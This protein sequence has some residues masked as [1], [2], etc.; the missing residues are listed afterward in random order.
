M[1][2]QYNA[3]QPTDF[4][5]FHAKG[6]EGWSE[7]NSA[8]C[9]VQKGIGSARI[10]LP[11][12]EINRL[13]I[14]FGN[15]PGTVEIANITLKGA[16]KQVL[17]MQPD[18]YRL[19]GIQ[20]FTSTETGALRMHCSKGTDPYAEYIPTLSCPAGKHRVF[21]WQE[22]II[23]ILLP[24]IVSYGAVYWWRNRHNPKPAPR[25]DTLHNVEFLRILFTLGVLVAHFFPRYGI[26]QSGGQGVE[27]FFL[28]SGYLLAVT[29][30]PGRSILLFAEQ[31]W[32]RF[33]PLVVVGG[34][35]ANGGLDSF[36]GV[37]MLQNTGLS[38]GDIPNAP[39]W[40]IAVLF[41]CSI[42]Y[43]ALLKTLPHQKCLLIAGVISFISYILIVQAGGN[44]LNLVAGYIPR[45]VF[46]GL[47]GMGLGIILAHY[48]RR[49]NEVYTERA[50]ALLYTLAELAVL[51]YIIIGC[52]NQDVFS[53]F[54]I[55]KPISHVALLSLFIVKRGYLTRWLEHP[56]FSW[57]AKY[58]LGIYLTH[59]FFRAHQFWVGENAAVS[60]SI[61]MVG[62]CILGAL[63][64]YLVE[65]PC[66]DG[67]TRLLNYLKS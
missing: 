42:L 65:K 2:F 29:Y 41:W 36:Y 59:W 1:V 21:L 61:A 67:L 48:I 17:D 25:R 33:V 38:M 55:C 53:R 60:I 51:G 35:L 10:L 56:V 32:I 40:Y 27:F 12:K 62:S 23:A 46:R 26:W 8:R 34:V 13:R 37:L 19:Y 15:T 31:K 58:C 9:R 47:A 6:H 39:A 66:A 11:A 52:F 49:N 24:L 16:T 14:D 45:G 64:Y 30:K 57:G 63:A 7:Q 18:S 54:W 22:F 28:L 3:Q 20:E 50:K 4:Q 44:R 5:I 43:L